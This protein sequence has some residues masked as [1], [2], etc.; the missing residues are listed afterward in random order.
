[1]VDGSAYEGIIKTKDG[2]DTGY[3]IQLIS[4]IR[5]LLPTKFVISKNGGGLGYSEKI[6]KLLLNDK[7]LNSSGLRKK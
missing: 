3:M 6:S 5:G 2:K 1:V 4:G 7:I